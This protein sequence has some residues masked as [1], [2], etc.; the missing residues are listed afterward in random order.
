MFCGNSGCLQMRE[1]K[2]AK[3]I[4]DGP[5]TRIRSKRLTH[6]SQPGDTNITPDLIGIL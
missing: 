4:N 3:Q 1:P 5:V 6:G 2:K